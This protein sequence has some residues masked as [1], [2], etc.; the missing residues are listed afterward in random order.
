VHQQTFVR[1]AASVLAL[2]AALAPAAARAQSGRGFF[3]AGG[4]G[5]ERIREEGAGPAR[6]SSEVGFR[7]GY[8]FT[9]GAALMI[10]SAVHGMDA[11]VGGDTVPAPLP[12]GGTA[13]AAEKRSLTTSSLLVAVQ[14]GVPQG[15][16]VRPAVGFGSHSFTVYDT[17]AYA[18]RTAHEGGPAAQLAVGHTLNRP[19]TI[20]IEALGLYSHGEDSTSPRWTAGVQLT[21]ELRF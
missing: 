18:R 10:E 11:H 15:W 5:V 21:Y 16:Y 8:R 6:F 13:A 3:L 4:V 12:G 1:R 7:A 2:A 20:G 19:G 9:P 14:L 17:N